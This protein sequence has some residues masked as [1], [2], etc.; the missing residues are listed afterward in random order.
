[1]MKSKYHGREGEELKKEEYLVT[2]KRVRE[3]G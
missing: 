2:W 1:M 3:W